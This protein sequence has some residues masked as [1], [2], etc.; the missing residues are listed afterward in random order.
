[1]KSRMHYIKNQDG[2]QEEMCELMDQY[3]EK[4]AKEAVNKTWEEGLKNTIIIVKS[5]GKSLDETFDLIKHR[6]D[7]KSVTREQIAKYYD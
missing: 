5:L 2:G 3:A 1:M 7:Y 6:D 4:Y